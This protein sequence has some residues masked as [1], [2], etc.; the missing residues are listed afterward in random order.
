MA[1]NR[2]HACLLT[3]LFTLITVLFHSSRAISLSP[4][5]FQSNAQ[6]DLYIFQQADHA[7]GPLICVV[8]NVSDRL[9]TYSP[10]L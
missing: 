6:L 9:G 7:N 1:N 5:L 10:F 3:V 2:T 4:E 8:G